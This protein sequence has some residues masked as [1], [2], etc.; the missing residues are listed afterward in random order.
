MDK[1]VHWVISCFPNRQF[2]IRRNRQSNIIVHLFM[3]NFVSRLVIPKVEISS[4]WTR[5]CYNHNHVYS[6]WSRGGARGGGQSPPL[7]FRPNW[8]PKGQKK[9]FQNF[10]GDRLPHLS[11]GLDDWAPP[12]CEGLDR[13]LVWMSPW[14]KFHI[15]ILHMKAT[16]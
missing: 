5:W 7:I 2:I 3:E 15:V 1:W 10:L 16:E 13:P 8:G 6:G 4:I 12:L 14:M 11:Q 9:V